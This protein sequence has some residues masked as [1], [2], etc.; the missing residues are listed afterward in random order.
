[1]KKLSATN[2][3]LQARAIQDGPVTVAPCGDDMILIDFSATPNTNQSVRVFWA[4]LESNRPG[5][6]LE[7]VAAVSTLSV[8]LRPEYR[9]TAQ[10]R[11]CCQELERLANDSLGEIP[12]AGVEKVIPVCYEQSM[13]PDLA[14]V[15]DHTG[16]DTLEVVKLHSSGV[17]LA[18]V[19][20]FMPGFAYMSG[21]DS[22][23]AVPRLPTPRP[24]VP[25]GSLGITGNQCAVY[26]SATP[27][28]WNLIGRSP[29]RL[30]DPLRTVPSF[31]ELGD[32]VR[33]ES[34]SAAAFDRLWAKR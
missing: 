24:V 12:P 3:Q 18:E 13:A 15:A 20:G 32:T 6:C 30:F 7:S 22:R 27:G 8:V 25:A 29:I 10:R 14:R 26:P 19:M 1:M 5:Y 31:L 9:S 21:L 28:G 33:F 11:I 34:I 17:Y 2:A 4:K 16:L 23:L